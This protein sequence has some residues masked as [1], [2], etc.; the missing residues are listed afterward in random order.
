MPKVDA[1]RM[2]SSYY[3]FVLILS[4]PHFCGPEIFRSMMVLQIFNRVPMDVLPVSINL[5]N[6][7]TLPIHSNY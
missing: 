2:R 3:L 6:I 4:P 5:L 7:F 1:T